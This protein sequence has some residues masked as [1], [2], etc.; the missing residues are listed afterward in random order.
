MK[1]LIFAAL[2]VSFNSYSYETYNMQQLN[3]AHRNATLIWMKGWELREHHNNKVILIDIQLKKYKDILKV[4]EDRRIRL[5]SQ[6][7][8][9]PDQPGYKD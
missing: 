1:Y 8:D 2:L 5:K 6:K 9:W 4:I 7:E 3:D